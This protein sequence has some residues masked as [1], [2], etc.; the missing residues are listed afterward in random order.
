MSKDLLEIDQSEFF[1]LLC[2]QRDKLHSRQ[3]K[4]PKEIEKQGE[5]ATQE[6]EKLKILEQEE[7]TIANRLC[8]IREEIRHLV[9]EKNQEK[10]KK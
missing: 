6:C 2:Q 10:K 1:K 4:L 7:K 9:V 8:G 3:K 5:I